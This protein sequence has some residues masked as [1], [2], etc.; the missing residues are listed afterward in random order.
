MS[1][2]GEPDTFVRTETPTRR[3]GI[4]KI[5]QTEKSKELDHIK[6]LSRSLALDYPPQPGEP[7]TALDF[8]LR[9]VVGD[10]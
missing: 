5:V 4:D 9:E 7:L 2:N 8:F 1:I 6:E 10:R 3:P